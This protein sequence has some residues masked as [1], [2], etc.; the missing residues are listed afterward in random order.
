MKYLI[1]ISLILMSTLSYSNT[2]SSEINCLAKAIYFESKGGSEQ[3][4]KDVGHVVLN[5][6]DSHKYPPSVCSVVYQRYKATCQFS[7]AC[8]PNKIT[9]P[10]EFSKA[11]SYATELFHEDL[12]G[13]RRDTTNKALF[14]H[15]KGFNPK[16]YGLTKCHANK[17]HV[18]YKSGSR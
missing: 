18:F 8:H 16:W 4:M 7:W 9:E 5:R 6:F 14:F 12:R 1:F 13:E 10:S 17:Q 3:D 11:K 15:T 2:T